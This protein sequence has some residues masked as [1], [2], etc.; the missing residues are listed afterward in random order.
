MDT[1]NTTN[2][3]VNNPL[4][5]QPTIP[6]GTAGTPPVSQPSG[7][8]SPPASSSTPAPAPQ[9][10]KS[11]LWVII[12]LIFSFICGL[13]VVAWYFQTQLQQLMS[14]SEVTTLPAEVPKE[15][16]VGTDATFHLMEY[17]ASDGALLGYDIDF[18]EKIGE[19]LGVKVTFKNI[20]WDDLFTALENKEIDMIISSVTITEERKQ[21]YD[22]STEYL[23][24]GQVVITQR[25]NASISSSAATLQGKRIGV[26]E[27]TTNEQKA[28]TLTSENLVIRYPDF[29]QATQALVDGDVDAILADLPGG[30]GIVTQNPTL[31][32]VSDP[33]TN[34]YYG[35]VFRKND[36]NLG[37][38]NETISI[39]KTKGVL[40]DLKQKW[41]D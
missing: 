26:Q 11:M 35:I 33:L 22:F 32:I 39:L 2:P 36:P 34:E 41:F 37:R 24:A 25:T 3:P 20:P 14:P 28:L 8:S 23:N 27:G 17:V 12:L 10:G 4:G 7:V 31:K 19:E 18:G 15:I 6:I 38:I 21:Q 1:N 9:K 30:K 40:T 13:G 16:I 5:V 29:V